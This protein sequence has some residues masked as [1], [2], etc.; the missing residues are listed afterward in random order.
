MYKEI[1]GLCLFVKNPKLIERL[2]TNLSDI[3][4]ACF[5]VSSI[6][7]TFSYKNSINIYVYA[8]TVYRISGNFRVEKFLC[9]KFS[10]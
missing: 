6:D 1:F 10:C 7:N 2:K 9:V 4:D 8:C 5:L 3:F